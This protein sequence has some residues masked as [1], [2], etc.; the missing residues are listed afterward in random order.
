MRRLAEMVL[1]P[2]INDAQDLTVIPPDTSGT[3]REVAGQRI[4]ALRRRLAL[5]P[6]DPMA[7][8]ELARQHTLTGSLKNAKAAMRVAITRAPTDRYL[9]RATARLHHH[10]GDPE[11]AH[12]LLA[13]AAPTAGDPWLIAA[14]ITLA[15]LTGRASRFLRTGR[16]MLE[17]GIPPIHLSEL[18]SV[19]ATLELDTGRAA[20]ARRLFGK[21][22]ED[23]NDNALAQAEWAASHINLDL[24]Q[25]LRTVPSSWEARA[26]AAAAAGEAE[27]AVKE[28]WGWFYDQPFAT[29]P[30]IFGSYEAAK[31][32]QFQQ[33]AH[34]ASR[35]IVANP[36]SFLLHNNLAFC[37]AKQGDLAGAEEQ[38]RSIHTDQLDRDQRATVEATYGLI[39]FRA[40]KPVEGAAMYT[41]A[42]EAFTSPD[43]RVLA[44][45]NL[46]IETFR[47]DPHVG[48]ALARKS[49]EEAGKLG[50]PRDRKAWLW[51]LEAVRTNRQA[52]RNR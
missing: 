52:G 2:Q 18:A 34:F 44:L 11:R 33:G 13:Q 39:A 12:T 26:L 49:H 14:E 8:A 32:G 16:R 17:S 50:A 4:A 10:I 40:G 37:L 38:L 45:I 9:L 28:A 35:A 41:R 24:S 25:H 19:L 1:N 7:W 22:L 47:V 43:N 42:M 30:A 3:D 29:G 51:Q 27:V 46:A 31:Y 21:A 6:D 36:T 5:A 48:E 15:N 20:Q 23:P